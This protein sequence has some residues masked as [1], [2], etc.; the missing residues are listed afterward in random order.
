MTSGAARLCIAC[1]RN[2]RRYIGAILALG[3][4]SAWLTMSPVF[5]SGGRYPQISYCNA[6][7]LL[8]LGEEGPF[9]KANERCLMLGMLNG[10]TKIPGTCALAT[11]F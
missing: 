5:P 8:T 2:A 4:H 10:H 3:R 1:E 6:E 11:G 7:V 9:R